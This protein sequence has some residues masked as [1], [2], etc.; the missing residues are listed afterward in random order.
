MNCAA[1]VESIAESELFGHVKGAFT[2]A[3]ANRP[4][5][6][7]LAD[8]GTL[9]LD[10]IGELPLSVQPMLLRALQSGEIQRVGA[11]RNIKVDVRVLAATNRVLSE[12]V[13]AG[14]FRADLYH[15]LSVY[16][17]NVPPLRDRDIALLAGHFLDQA[18]IKLGLG[19]TRFAAAALP[20]STDEPPSESAA[21][22]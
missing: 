15:R 2:G 12:E 1:L 3:Q 21:K 6:F 13:K 14:R 4:G 16:P 7:E 20:P 5:K 22:L 18:R 11:D 17:V 10:E 19:R 8:G 9:F